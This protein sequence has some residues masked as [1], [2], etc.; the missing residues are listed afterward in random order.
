[1]E[2]HT[3]PALLKCDSLEEVQTLMRAVKKY[4]PRRGEK[5]LK[6]NL[7]QKLNKCYKVMG[8][9]LPKLRGGPVIHHE[10]TNVWIVNGVK[11]LDEQQ[12]KKELA[13][14]AEQE[15]ETKEG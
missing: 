4:W 14:Y 10:L 9:G 11:F 7:M 15:S 6:L 8:Q 1:M 3:N 2:S 13:K 5:T 12:A